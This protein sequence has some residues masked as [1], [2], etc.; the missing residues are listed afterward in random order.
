ML[1]WISW[2][3]PTTADDDRGR[4]IYEKK[5]LLAPLF[6]GMEDCPRPMR[7]GDD[8]KAFFGAGIPV[9]RPEHAATHPAANEAAS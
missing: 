7:L 6:P 3:R 5:D 9:G 1:P 8:E 4:L 2:I